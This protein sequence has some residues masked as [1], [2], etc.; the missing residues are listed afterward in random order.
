MPF[1]RKDLV[2]VG[3]GHAHVGV[4]KMI[5][6]AKSKKRWKPSTD[7]RI[8]LIAKELNTPYR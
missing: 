4:L 2:L 5:A 7:T 6:M 3:G 1:W 8:T